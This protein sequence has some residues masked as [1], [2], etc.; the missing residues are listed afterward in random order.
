VD[1]AVNGVLH[2]S[3]DEKASMGAPGMWKHDPDEWDRVRLKLGEAI[4]K[5]AQGRQ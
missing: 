2:G 1:E 3:I 5:L 4:A